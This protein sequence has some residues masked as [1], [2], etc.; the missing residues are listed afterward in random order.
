[1]TLPNH[2]ELLGRDGAAR[3]GR[4]TTPH[5]VVCTPAFMPVGTAGAVEGSHRR[6]VRANGTDIGLRNTYHLM[7]RPGAERVERCFVAEA[8]LQQRVRHAGQAPKPVAVA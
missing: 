7:L 1:M 5:G 2:F 8:A 6:Q 4:L 3:L